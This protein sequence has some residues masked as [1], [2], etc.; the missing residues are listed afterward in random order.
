MKT[1]Y[2]DRIGIL[3]TGYQA[4]SV[5]VEYDNNG[6]KKTYYI[7]TEKYFDKS[8]NNQKINFVNILDNDTNLIF[9][10]CLTSKIFQ[11]L[12]I[13]T[14][15]YHFG[16]VV[17]SDNFLLSLPAAYSESFAN[18]D[19]AQISLTEIYKFFKLGSEQKWSEDLS[20]IIKGKKLD[21]NSQS[22][23]EYHEPRIWV[24][25]NIEL[26]KKFF[27]NY[28]TI[29]PC[30]IDVDYS[31]IKIQLI[32]QVIGDL[33][34][35]NSDRHSGNVVL[36][37]KIYNNPEGRSCTIRLAPAFDFGCTFFS[38]FNQNELKN[39]IENKTISYIMENRMKYCMALTKYNG[40]AGHNDFYLVKDYIK[41]LKDKKD[42]TIQETEIL[43]VIENAKKI[44][45]RDCFKEMFVEGLNNTD[46]SMSLD[47]LIFLYNKQMKKHI[48]ITAIENVEKL[49]DYS[50]KLL[51]DDNPTH[52]GKYT[53]LLQ[54][55]G[56]IGV[57]DSVQQQSKEMS[58][59]SLENAKSPECAMGDDA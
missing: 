10:E 18:D 57:A 8:N 32:K 11:K 45:I 3:S 19:E 15:S 49:F 4:K 2:S 38:E 47:E 24:D 41:M 22:R 43:K 36:V 23:Q 9:H 20:A 39:L 40:Y 30:G 37:S 46:N 55:V 25:N 1:F 54:E 52:N 17:N 13:E 53:N 58:K 50:R 59:T 27:A 56:F 34:C 6:K 5:G 12:G 14:V 44:N 26:M 16:E 31:T 42:R 28:E 48:D 29:Y 21:Y 33:L 7:K 35:F 51:L